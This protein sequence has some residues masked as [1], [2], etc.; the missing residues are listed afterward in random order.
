MKSII[1]PLT[2]KIHSIYSKKGRRILRKFI[3]T[4]KG[5]MN[6]KQ[7][8]EEE[9]IEEINIA[10]SD[11]EEENQFVNDLIR[12]RNRIMLRLPGSGH[13]ERELLSLLLFI[14]RMSNSS[15][16]SL[17]LRQSVSGS[18]NEGNDPRFLMKHIR[19]WLYDNELI[20]NR[21]SFI[22]R[23]FRIAR[24]EQSNHGYT[25]LLPNYVDPDYS[26]VN[27]TSLI[28]NTGNIEEK[29]ERLI[30]FKNRI[31]SLFKKS[32]EFKKIFGS[33]D[34]LNKEVLSLEGVNVTNHIDILKNILRKYRY[35]P[36]LGELRRLF[37]ELNLIVLYEL[38]PFLS[39]LMNEN[40]EI[41][42]PPLPHFFNIVLNVRMQ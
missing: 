8:E 5:G 7:T 20:R 9:D 22:R 31:V 1:D 40:E 28:E 14:Y 30:E 33:L 39:T 38:T 19:S 15:H 6:E 35:I 13:I 37:G 27:R 16:N 17:V 34:I 21:P 12:D 10:N 23:L 26:D 18:T 32:S 24:Q 29:I 4:L 42:E 41:F 3:N 36:E 2:N 11:E 25:F